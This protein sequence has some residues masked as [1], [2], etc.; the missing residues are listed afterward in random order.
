MH[1]H[2]I[3]VALLLSTTLNITAQSIQRL[4]EDTET[5]KPQKYV[6]NLN[7]YASLKQKDAVLLTGI[8][9]DNHEAQSV[10]IRLDTG[11]N[12]LWRFKDTSSAIVIDH[13]FADDSLV[14][15]TSGKYLYKIN[16]A[17]GALFFRIN[18]NTTGPYDDSHAFEIGQDSLLILYWS[19]SIL[20]HAYINKSTGVVNTAPFPFNTNLNVPDGQKRLYN[21]NG[22]YLTKI[23]TDLQTVLW[24]DTLLVSP[25]VQ[26]AG[27]PKI[28]I[29][30]NGR[31]F[32]FCT[33]GNHTKALIKQINPVNGSI[34]WQKVLTESF[35]PPYLNTLGF[36]NAIEKEDSIYVSWAT[37]HSNSQT[38]SPYLVQKIN[39]N[40]GAEFWSSIVSPVDL[41]VTGTIAFG[42]YLDIDSKS[43]IYLSGVCGGFPYSFE[44]A[45]LSGPTG[46]VVWSKR[47]DLDTTSIDRYSMGQGVY[48]IND[49][50]YFVG[51]LEA[52]EDSTY[53]NDRQRYFGCIKV[54]PTNGD[55]VFIRLFAGN[56]KYPS[57]IHSIKKY[58]D[59]AFVALST[60]GRQINVMMLDNNL[61][62]IWERHYSSH[63]FF[64]GKDL[65]V[66]GGLIYI[67]AYR[68]KDLF[69][70]VEFEYAFLIIDSAGNLVDNR[71]FDTGGQ[72]SV[73]T[74][75][76]VCPLRIF[77]HAGGIIVT[78]GEY[79]DANSA[80]NNSMNAIS[81]RNDSMS[82][83]KSLYHLSNNSMG[84]LVDFDSASLV[85]IRN[86][87]IRVNKSTLDTTTHTTA[88]FHFTS[89]RDV[90]KVSQSD[91]IL[92]SGGNTLID[93][94]TFFSF[95]YATSVLY[96]VNTDSVV[97]TSLSSKDSSVGPPMGTYCEKVV[98]GESGKL[99]ALDKRHSGAGVRKIDYA[100][101]QVLWER[102]YERD[103]G[104]LD[105]AFKDIAYNDYYKKVV[106]A[107]TQK[108][109][110]GLDTI[111]DIVCFTYNE[112]GDL[113]DSF[114][115][116]GIK[117]KYNHVAQVLAMGQKGN[118]IAGTFE[119]PDGMSSGYLARLG[120]VIFAS[121]SVWPGDANEDGIVDATDLLSLGI[122]YGQTGVARAVP[123]IT[124]Q[125]QYCSNWAQTLPD[126]VNYKFAD[127]N[128]NGTVEVSD[129]GAIIQNFHLMHTRAADE[130]VWVPGAPELAI[131]FSSD[132]FGQGQT[133]TG[134]ILLGNSANPLTACYGIT[135]HLRFNA[136][137]I[138]SNSIKIAPLNSWLISSTNF[139][140]IGKPGTGEF[141]SGIVGTD[142]L[143]KSGYGKIG[144]ISFKVVDSIFIDNFSDV[145]SFDNVTAIDNSLHR[146]SINA[147][148]NTV[149]FTR[150][151]LSDMDNT[152][153]DGSYIIY[154]NPATSIL[155]LNNDLEKIDQINLYRIDGQKVMAI[156]K[157]GKSSFDISALT[158]GVYIA[159]IT[160]KDGSRRLKWVKM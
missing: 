127:C 120:N 139:L 141:Y 49:I 128:G 72:G 65:E 150:S 78:Y 103:S 113:I 96:N 142:H 111:V 104:F 146:I 33:T 42:N 136:A 66:Y 117:S 144:E 27:I 98:P 94:G 71:F 13:I 63:C 12:T 32:V 55:T 1:K 131:L 121:D 138:N 4:I 125:P 61:N 56:T 22:P 129:T 155:N 77:N 54:N 7:L 81:Y 5:E 126:G 21:S 6:A 80:A 67:N 68:E 64:T 102:T 47:I 87:V 9:Y 106:A 25:L 145:I 147:V 62:T 92:I 157:P 23:D 88:A 153:I 43:D 151:V 35:N 123:D 8:V 11:G 48:V 101:G 24:K 105:L 132:T 152:T 118:F 30:R 79:L 99:Y 158:N 84:I 148:S 116:P 134:D 41:G 135:F 82:A 143:N 108:R 50:P 107:G 130:V 44:S 160:T 156:N 119:N 124:W 133:I 89:M 26:V 159:E 45:K 37:Q 137:Y 91:F 76:T 2:L 100:S 16:S 154:P 39:K 74:L 3:I 14:Y 36:S 114:I 115:K 40:N 112:T 110:S 28:L 53:W 17:T 15:A 109:L 18:Y 85:G 57:A 19:N 149:T 90:I 70:P 95:P 20:M 75:D 51:T 58:S 86:G 93:S 140:A 52:V 69:S 83:V 29:D 46:T 31:V 97:W 10:V 34:I 38:P 73:S 122:A 59:N 60:T